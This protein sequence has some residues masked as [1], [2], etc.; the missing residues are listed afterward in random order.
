MRAFRLGVL[1]LAAAA[2]LLTACGGGDDDDAGGN[3]GDDGGSAGGST[4]LLIDATDFA[5]DPDFY[6]V[7]TGET[8]SVSLS[9]LGAVEHNWV[10]VTAGNEITSSVDVDESLFY[11]ELNAQAGE[12]IGTT[13]TAPA[14]G[15]YQ[16]ICSI[17]GHIEAGMV[18]E[19]EVLG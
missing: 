18:A 2:L 13:F 14:P 9:N 5:F 1:A 17:S 10:I 6:E 15:T 4:E 8:I 19:L 16:V 3:G 7:P 11:F 12:S